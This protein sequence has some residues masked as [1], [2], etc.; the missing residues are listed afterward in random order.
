MTKLTL[1]Q[2]AKHAK[3]SKGTISKALN[4]GNLS[5]EKVSKNGRDTWEID[6]SE[7]QRW[8]DVNP[9]REHKEVQSTTPILNT[10]NATGNSA[11]QVEVKMLREQ[12]GNLKDERS[13][14]RDQLLDQIDNLRSQLERQSDDHR[15]AMAVLEDQRKAATD[16]PKRGLWARLTG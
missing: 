2:A 6:P 11:L 15:K 10:E 1:G 5:G 12:I 7:L 3:R 9:L 13:N 16:A 8:M 4:N 14:E